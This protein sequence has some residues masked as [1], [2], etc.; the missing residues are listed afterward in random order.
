M[1]GQEPWEFLLERNE[2]KKDQRK[3]NLLKHFAKNM[4]KNVLH[5]QDDISISKQKMIFLWLIS[6]STLCIDIVVYC[7]AM[8]NITAIKGVY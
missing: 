2:V 5:F 3:G 7:L 4:Q 8:S 1:K 6:I